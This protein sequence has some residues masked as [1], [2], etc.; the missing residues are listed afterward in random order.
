VDLGLGTGAVPDE[1]GAI[2]HEL[3]PL[4]DLGRRDPALGQAPEGQ[5]GAQVLGVAHVVLD[6]AIAPVVPERMGQVDAGA[7][8]LED[9]GRPV[10]AIGGFQDHLGLGPGG[11][12]GLGELEGLARDPHAAE[13]LDSK[14]R[15]RRCPAAFFLAGIIRH[16]YYPM[17]EMKQLPP[18]DV[19]ELM[20]VFVGALT[21]RAVVIPVRY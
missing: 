21:E 8:V 12:H 14:S 5:H 18:A 4:S 16:R 1:R 7:E 11:G 10:P 6:P 2:T 17:K 9:V 13:D 3:A 20:L 19:L 15:R